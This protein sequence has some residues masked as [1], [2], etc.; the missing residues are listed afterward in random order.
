MRRCSR[1]LDSFHGQMAAKNN[2]IYHS[3]STLERISYLKA[4]D[5]FPLSN[6]FPGRILCILESHRMH[7]PLS[8]GSFIFA[9]D[10][11]RLPT[12]FKTAKEDLKANVGK[13]S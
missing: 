9:R 1:V 3:I 5:P 7:H 8:L 10:K 6:G 12:G 4:V 2:S 11:P 13:D